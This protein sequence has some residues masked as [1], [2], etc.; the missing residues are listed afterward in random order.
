MADNAIQIMEVVKENCSTHYNTVT[1]KI[2]VKR[3]AFKFEIVNLP[4]LGLFLKWTFICLM[5]IAVTYEISKIKISA[6]FL[7][8]LNFH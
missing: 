7:D 6:D 2:Y 4:F 8:S 5:S 1:T 3:D